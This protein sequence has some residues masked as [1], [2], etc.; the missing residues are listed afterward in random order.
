[1]RSVYFLMHLL[2][3]TSYHIAGCLLFTE[4][5]RHWLTGSAH[6]SNAEK[7]F[8]FQKPAKLKLGANH[9]S[10]LGATVGFPVMSSNYLSC[11]SIFS[12]NT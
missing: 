9:I 4:S 5:V 11:S 10:L 8:V 12:G 6:G 1:M 3:M 7:S 2:Q